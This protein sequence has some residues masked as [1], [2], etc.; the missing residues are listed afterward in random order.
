MALIC[1]EPAALLGASEE[2]RALCRSR[3]PVAQHRDD[4]GRAMQHEPQ[5]QETRAERAFAI[6]LLS[7]SDHKSL[8][9]LARNESCG[10]SRPDRDRGSIAQPFL[11]PIQGGN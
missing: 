3:P 8:C 2:A 10:E 9:E 6:N 5:A 4:G 11:N 1:D 7:L